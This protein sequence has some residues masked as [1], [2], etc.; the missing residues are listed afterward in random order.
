[1][2]SYT[3]DN[4]FSTANVPAELTTYPQWVC[5]RWE[6]DRK[7]GKWKKVPFDPR[8]GKRAKPTDSATWATL[9]EATTA[10]LEKRGY[11]GLGFVLTRDDPY[12]VIDLDGCR[13]PETGEVE[14]WALEIVRRLASLTV[15]SPSGT[16]LHV[17]VKGTLLHLLDEDTGGFNKKQERGIEGYSAI[18]YMTFT[19]EV[20]SGESIEERQE[21][22]E[23][24]YR[25]L[26]PEDET[27]GT[28]STGVDVRH[29][30]T[31]E[32]LLQKARSAGK[33][34]AQFATLYD[35]GYAGSDHSAADAQLMAMLAFWTGKDSERM[36]RLFSGSA[37]GQR[38]KWKNTPG[39]RERTIRHAIK[40]TR[41]VYDPDYAPGE[42]K[43]RRGLRERMGYAL[44]VHPWAGVAGDAKSAATDYFGYRAVLRMACKANKVEIDLSVRDYQIGAGLGSYKTAHASLTRLEHDHGL[45]E[46][47]KDGNAKD[48]ATYRVKAVSIRDHTL[49]DTGGQEY[50]LTLCLFKCDPLLTP[51]GFSLLRTH[52]IRHPSPLMPEY[53]RNGRKIPSSDDAPERSIG[54]P[55]AW[56]FDMVYAF[57]V[58][59]GGSA[60]LNFLAERTGTDK[61]NL[62]RRH[63][64]D[65]LDANLTE[66]ADGDSYAV[67]EKVEVRLRERLLAT[68]ALTKDRRTRERVEEQRRLQRVEILHRSGQDSDTIA[69]ETGLTVVQVE[70]VLRPADPAPTAE[71][72][73]EWRAEH[74]PDGEIHEL[75]K[76]AAEWDTFVSSDDTQQP[77]SEPDRQ[78]EPA[79]AVEVVSLAE[80]RSNRDAGAA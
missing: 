44:F 79:T 2:E 37:L 71:E 4:K 64:K 78:P 56:I 60:S 25:D 3:I 5:W 75:E 72:M 43:V 19:G 67:P 14:S 29:D 7:K 41:K 28:A 20:F 42:N 36:E 73:R 53:D 8:T 80:Y 33:T 54:K 51:E 45:I 58:L 13:D 70:A 32:E 74:N 61:K 16:G 39:Y 10:L 77:I 76:H 26:Y 1:M 27:A 63:V 21:E 69:V 6:K 65:L 46:K 22:V 24:L 12:T 59:T 50:S 17:W 57:H 18:H 31:D 47:T 11:N 38:G 52:L 68:G 55:A 49:I 15:V 23:D 35:V 62:K 40:R 9:T 66:S 30:L 34:G 48:A